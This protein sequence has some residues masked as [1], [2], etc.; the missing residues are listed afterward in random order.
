MGQCLE[1]ELKALLP[2]SITE[3]K[4]Q[5]VYLYVYVCIHICTHICKKMC[6][7]LSYNLFHASLL[8]VS[9]RM[10]NGNISDVPPTSFQ[11]KRSFQDGMG[12][13]KLKE[14]ELPL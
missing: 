7:I 4:E 10:P 2:H 3:T 6:N 8:V 13:G 9:V 1:K 5:V 12:K 14:C 11:A